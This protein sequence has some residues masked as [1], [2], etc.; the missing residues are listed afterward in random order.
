MRRIILT[1]LAATLLLGCSRIREEDHIPV[2]SLPE[3]TPATLC[4]SFGN[5]DLM[6]L[7][8]GTKAEASPADEARI[9]DLYV[10]IFNNSNGNKIYGRFFSYE[11]L[12]SSIAT[13]T[14]GNNEGWWVE[15]K[16]LTGVT[17]SISDTRGVVKLS[18]EICHDAKVVL[19]ANVVNAVS[20]LDRD[21]DTSDGDSDVAYDDDIS[22]LND[23]K[24][25]S[26]LQRTKVI[27]EQDVVNR[28]DLFLMMGTLP[29]IDTEQM[30][31]D[32]TADY[33]TDYKIELRPLDAKVK[34]M[35]RCNADSNPS[36]FFIKDAKAVYWKACSVPDRCYLFSDYAGGAAPDDVM[37]FDSESAYFEGKESKDGYDWFVFSF[38]MLESSHEK[39]RH[40]DSYYQREKQDTRETDDN[41]YSYWRI[42]NGDKVEYSGINYVENL[43]WYYAPDN[44]PYV[45]FDMVLELTQDGINDMGGGEVGEAMTSDTIYTVH[46][47]DFTNGAQQ[48]DDYNTLRS[49]FYTYKIVIANSGSIFAEV[50]NNLENEPGQEGFLI[51][52]NDEI[53]NAD[54]HY[55]YHS[56]SFTYTPGLSATMFSWYVKTPFSE[57]RPQTKTDPDNSN[58][59]IYVGDNTRTDG[60]DP[61]DYKWCKFAVN[62]VVGGEYTTN[63]VKYMGEKDPV[64][65]D[66]NYDPTWKPSKGTPHPPLMDISQLIEYIVDQNNKPLAENDFLWDS[67]EGKNIIR[68]TIFIDEYYY[69]ENPISGEKDQDLWRHFVNAK[70]REM[71]I[72][73]DARQSRDKASDVI[74]S[75]H[76][77]IQ[78][79][80]QT[81]YNIYSPGLRTLWG[82]EHR[83]EIKEKVPAGWQYWPATPGYPKRSGAN[84]ALGKENGRLN[85]AYIWNLYDKQDASGTES[86]NKEWETYMT[87]EVDND[88][89]ELKT[90]Y[91]GLAFSCMTRNRDNNGNG[92]IDREEVRWYL[93]ASEQLIGI[94]VGNESLS[95]SA[96]LYQP[97]D[98]C[99]Y[100]GN[101]YPKEWRSHVIS[102]T[103]EKV[104]W[105]EE[106][107]GATDLSY[108]KSPG[109]PYYTW[110]TWDLATHGESVRCIRNI[111]TIDGAEGLQDISYAPYPTTVDKYFT[112]ETTYKNPSDPSSQPVGYT[113]SFDRLNTKSIREYS[114]GEL[115]Y[116]EQTSLT[117]R[118]YSKMITQNLL[119]DPDIDI[120][121]VSPNITTAQINPD[122]TARGNNPYCPPGYRFP[123]F[124]EWV[125]MSLYLS[126]D[127]LR[128]DKNG[129]SYSPGN[130]MP[131]RTYYDKGYYGSLK[132]D[133]EPWSTE[134]GKVGWNYSN[135]M[136]CVPASQKPTRSRCVKDEEMTGHINGDISLDSDYIYPDDDTPITLTLS[137]TASTLTAASL[138]LCYNAHNGNYREI[139]IPVKS[140]KGIEYRETQTVSIPSLADL[141]LTQDDIDAGHPMT[142]MATAINAWGNVFDVPPVD[143][144]MVNP[145]GGNMTGVSNVYP[146]ADG[147]VTFN[148]LSNARTAYLGG[149]TLKIRFTRPGE[150]SPSE[151]TIPLTT[152]P[153][154]KYYTGP[155]AFSIPSLASLGLTAENYSSVSDMEF[156]AR[157]EMEDHIYKEFSLP[158][159]LSNPVYGSIGG[160]GTYIYPAGSEESVTFDFHSHAASVALS[161]AVLK[162]QYTIP[163]DSDP[164]EVSLT[165]SSSPS[166]ADYTPTQTL[167]IPSLYALGLTA[168]DLPLV[169]NLHA[170]VSDVNGLKAVDDAAVTI[171]S[172]YSGLIDIEDGFDPT[173]GF[174]IA[175]SANSMTGFP[176]ESV[177]LRWKQGES[178]SYNLNNV[179][180]ADPTLISGHSSTAYWHPGWLDSTSDVVGC[181]NGVNDATRTYYFSAVVG[182]YDGE[183]H[184]LDEAIIGRTAEVAEATMEFLKI[185]YNPCPGNWAW[186][187]RP[188]NTLPYRWIPQTVSNIYFA[189]G[190]FIDAFLD[191]SNCTYDPKTPGVVD[192]TNDLG[193]DN[194]ITFGPSTQ[195][196][197]IGGV[198]TALSWSNGNVLFYYPARNGDN[199]NLQIAVHG[200][201]NISRVQPFNL[202]QDNLKIML[203][204]DLVNDKG[205]VL[206]NNFS[207]DNEHEPDW[208]SEEIRSY[209]EQDRNNIVTSTQNKL[210]DL[211]KSNRQTVYVG[212]TEGQH[213][214]RA[215]YKYV[216]VVRKHN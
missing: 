33:D 170:E 181:I 155:Q 139:D 189:S 207:P 122:V 126:E 25:F 48:F 154:G 14:S 28:K 156:I 76:S 128:K 46:L 196:E 204:R 94:W 80:I 2:G 82:C 51:L 174:P 138:K 53:V 203:K 34:F 86:P 9:H 41:S 124:K 109:D 197:N 106:G 12:K 44:A 89:P 65:G 118:V 98:A 71:H 140:P 201:S 192:G 40:A 70:P 17:P 134:S 21:R 27:L 55:A 194:L 191:V 136:H 202:P 36:N 172:H 166:T 132:S 200:G 105:A 108:D 178:G 129:N 153:N 187:N 146:S 214:S 127:Y 115:P 59:T 137:S 7:N 112:I 176:I 50:E 157:V 88:Q 79:S 211:T 205:V 13:L 198:S 123:N 148:F 141:G 37:Y 93:A 104:C 18:T 26:Q 83:D 38:Y 32:K 168:E 107:A 49:H 6:Q 135:K 60:L 208:Y 54:C 147:S 5:Q 84:T 160:V 63:R 57:G 209:S 216:R 116:H 77:V 120:Q 117:N 62:A 69:E 114:E 185:N 8:V 43:G 72:L 97:A 184:P 61:L 99:T 133:T 210:N 95:L 58:Y 199:N 151:L 39:K 100:N 131:S 47:G 173:Q 215:L 179:N 161:N 145:I 119:N 150:V 162:L 125:L 92:V 64:T 182:K 113:F 193:M 45:Q 15:N 1:C 159:Q 163:G 177:K 164:T 149:A 19:I 175:V 142:L 85:S 30:Q 183:G 144:T 190:D 56:V 213:R 167:T 75:S 102:S 101:S 81:I 195:S 67:A 68:V 96:R 20:S 121:A 90:G 24:K 42:V 111:G 78:Q 22:Y 4:I 130:I 103:A 73:S 188:P 74:Q 165:L 35:V 158:I 23:I 10:M 29:S 52:T 3:G 16:T 212:S 110:D 143:V 169:A 206:V 87:F 66:L 31:W 152:S 91:Q 171:K 180:V 186:N 11:H